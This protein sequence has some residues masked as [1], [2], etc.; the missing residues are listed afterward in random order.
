MFISHRLAVLAAQPFFSISL[1]FGRNFGELEQ[2]WRVLIIQVRILVTIFVNYL[3][4]RR[5][6]LKLNSCNNAYTIQVTSRYV[7]YRAWTV[8]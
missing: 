7:W 1:S 3:P 6:K 4:G 5:N 2:S 8:V